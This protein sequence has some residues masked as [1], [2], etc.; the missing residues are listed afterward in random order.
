MEKVV[1]IAAALSPNS[2]ARTFLT[3]F[4][5]EGLWKSLPHPPLS[6]QGEKFEYRM[7]DG[8]YNV[9]DAYIPSH[10]P[11]LTEQRRIYSSQTSAKLVLLTLE[12]HAD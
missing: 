11:S 5:T 12:R 9:C 7:P 4:L 10:Y 1:A 3:N 6:Y 2:K 8:S